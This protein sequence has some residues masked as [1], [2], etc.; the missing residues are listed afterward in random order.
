MMPN[1]DGVSGG[2]F[3]TRMSLCTYIWLCCYP[4]YSLHRLFILLLFL[5]FFKEIN[6]MHVLHFIT[7][8]GVATAIN[9]H[10]QEEPRCVDP[11]T[12]VE[13][14]DLTPDLQQSYID[15][16]LCLKTRPSRIGLNTSLYDDFPW[17][18]QKYNSIIHG[19]SPFL[20]W[21]RYFGVVYEEALHDCGYKG[22]APYW[23]WSLDVMKLAAS[24]VM[25]SKLGF[26]GDGSKTRTEVLSDGS[27][28]RCVD[29]GPFASL[30]PSY[31]GLS[32]LITVQEEHCLYRSLTDGDNASARVSARYYNSTYVDIVEEEATFETFHTS[33]EGGPHGIIHS[34][35]GGEMNPT[36]SPNE[37]IFFLHHVQIDRLWR[38]WQ[39]KDLA[40]REFDYTGQMKL[41]N[42]TT[43]I[44]AGLD[45]MLLMG[46]LAPDLRVRDVMSTNGRFCYQYAD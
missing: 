35:I 6:E 19:A 15:A 4:I 12:R 8:A 21:H 41:F 25:S 23:N 28:I 10:R 22:A 37:P 29:D 46:G 42:S 31:I 1:N 39:G 18:H 16:V 27:T 11:V 3:A 33:L 24:P 5:S 32:P 17:V 45:D 2:D 38:R 30:R 40:K 44:T 13:W 14:R 9:V 20:P 7:L 36:T 43:F 26:G 34:S